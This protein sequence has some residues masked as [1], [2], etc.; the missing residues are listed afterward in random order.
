MLTGEGEPRRGKFAHAT[1][2]PINEAANCQRA[3]PQLWR[4][5]RR[6]WRCIASHGI[7][8]SQPRVRGRGKLGT[9]V[10]G[11]RK[12][13]AGEG[14]GNGALTHGWG[15]LDHDAGQ[16]RARGARVSG[17]GGAW[18]ATLP[19]WVRDRCWRAVWDEQRASEGVESGGNGEER[20]TDAWGATRAPDA[21][22]TAAIVA[23]AERGSRLAAAGVGP[24]RPVGWHVHHVGSHKWQRL[25]RHG[26]PFPRPVPPRP[27]IRPPGS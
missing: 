1:A 11:S 20:N 9:G 10:V 8:R 25:P 22:T 6:P 15:A 24:S 26:A 17:W 4:I 3:V 13:R 19:A 7:E 21:S 12:W 5:L 18:G 23:T 14:G 16:G 2:G 27:F